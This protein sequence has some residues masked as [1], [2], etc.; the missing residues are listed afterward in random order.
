MTDQG[1]RDRGKRELRLERAR[2]ELL[3]TLKTLRDGTLTPKEADAVEAAIEDELIALR[4]GPFLRE[5]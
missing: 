3:E 5:R 2:R 1:K 4:V